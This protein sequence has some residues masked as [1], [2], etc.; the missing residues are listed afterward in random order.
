MG[1]LNS[2]RYTWT[3]NPPGVRKQTEPGPFVLHRFA[4]LECGHSH[5][6]LRV[7]LSARLARL[8]GQ[9]SRVT[10]N[11]NPGSTRSGTLRAY[12]AAKAVSFPSPAESY[13]EGR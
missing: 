10:Q 6:F 7:D 2:G 3:L 5:G 11:A 9:G 12:A 8:S 13:E 1:T 4:V